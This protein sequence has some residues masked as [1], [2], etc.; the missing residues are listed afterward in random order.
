MFTNTITHKHQYEWPTSPA[1]ESGA[2]EPVLHVHR[3]GQTLQECSLLSTS[4]HS[5]VWSALRV[6]S[7]QSAHFLRSRLRVSEVGA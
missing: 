5:N 2:D 4:A 1:D 3:S 7:F 6:M